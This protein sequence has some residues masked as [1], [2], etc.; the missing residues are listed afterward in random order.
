MIMVLLLILW[1]WFENYYILV[2]SSA[3]WANSYDF[4]VNSYDFWVN[5]LSSLLVIVFEVKVNIYGENQERLMH[6]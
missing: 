3:C 2:D 1:F 6:T 4:K 5:S